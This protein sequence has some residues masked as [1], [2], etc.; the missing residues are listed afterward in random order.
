ML[1]RRPIE[2]G[3]QCVKALL[4]G[5]NTHYDNFKDVPQQTAILNQE[6]GSIAG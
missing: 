4:G 6:V 3:L 1:A 5:W 2:K